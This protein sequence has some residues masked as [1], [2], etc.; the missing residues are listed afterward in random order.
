MDNINIFDLAGR[1]APYHFLYGSSLSFKREVN[2]NRIRFKLKDYLLKDDESDGLIVENLIIS[3]ANIKDETDAQKLI[4][5]AYF[6]IENFSVI[7]S[8]T[9]LNN[10]FKFVTDN[11]KEVRNLKVVMGPEKMT[12]YGAYKKGIT[13]TFAVD[14]KFEII[15]NRLVIV[16]DR[17]WAGN[18]KVALPKIFQK[19]LIS[20]MQ[21]YIASNDLP[22]K[23]VWMNN[24]NIFVDHI[25]MMPVNGLFYMKSLVIA[26]GFLAVNG[27]VD[28]EEAV[29][30]LERKEEGVHRAERIVDEQVTGVRT[31]GSVTAAEVPIR[32][33]EELKAKVQA[34]T[35]EEK[36]ETL[37]E[38]EEMEKQTEERLKTVIPEISH[39]EIEGKKVDEKVVIKK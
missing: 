10:A 38:I 22:V 5:S 35:T 33:R 24:Q 23:G 19:A 15:N 3:I 17:F 14:L 37:K 39:H 34:L 13:F 25:A 31:P 4:P 6:I 7:V 12:I 9:W 20:Y 1:V 36:T 16:L 21:G 11:M 29:R 28:F 30:I 32:D 8:E 2:N 27:G 18:R 26:D